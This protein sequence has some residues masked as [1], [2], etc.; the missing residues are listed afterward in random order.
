MSL[1]LNKTNKFGIHELK[2]NISNLKVIDINLKSNENKKSIENSPEKNAAGSNNDNIEQLILTTL[3]DKDI[4]DSWIFAIDIKQDHQLVIG[5]LKSLLPD[6]Y[7]KD[8]LIVTNFF[9]LSEE[10]KKVLQTGSPEYQVYSSVNTTGTPIND[11]Q[12]KL[13]EVFKIGLG[14]CLKNKW[15][16]KEAE[17]LIKID[18]NVKDELIELLIR[19]ENNTL[20]L[21]NDEDEINKNLK[22]RKLVTEIKRKSYKI[23]KGDQYQ[24]IRVK[25]VAGL[26]KE[27]LG[28]IEEV[29]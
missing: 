27:M 10:G 16:K 3:Q 11:L 20:I 6:Y 13:G 21:P 28:N 22:R 12:S 7:V 15:L 17:N 25:K 18:E 8:E 1:I 4:E 23:T 19:I 24:P 14:P 9:A 5:A 29:N 2:E 26:N